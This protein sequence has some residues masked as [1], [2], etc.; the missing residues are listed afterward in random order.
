M[1][2]N[3]LQSNALGQT[4]NWICVT[5]RG[6]RRRAE[7]GGGR[8]RHSFLLHLCESVTANVAISLSF[9]SF[10]I[11]LFR[12]IALRTA[13]RYVATCRAP[14]DSKRRRESVKWNC[15]H[16]NWIS[17]FCILCI[18]FPSNVDR[19]R[20]ARQV[21]RADATRGWSDCGEASARVS[22]A[23]KTMCPK[24]PNRTS[25][26]QTRP[27]SVLEPVIS[28][29]R[30]F[31]YTVVFFYWKNDGRNDGMNFLSCYWRLS[32]N[33]GCLLNFYWGD[34]IVVTVSR[35][36][37]SLRVAW[38]ARLRRGAQS[39]QGNTYLNQT[40]RNRLELIR[41]RFLFLSSWLEL[42]AT[43]SQRSPT[44]FRWWI[45]RRRGR[46]QSIFSPS[47]IFYFLVHHKNEPATNGVVSNQSDFHC[48]MN[49]FHL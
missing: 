19:V 32:F 35:M 15:C 21:R 45:A 27:L 11:L 39:A 7:A 2:N 12:E 22:V 49:D 47:F 23:A 5:E 6:W 10:L 13:H 8:L 16:S 25:G 41:K 42:E 38:H 26:S 40:D 24:V 18:I 43:A 20:K 9:Y 14:Y 33:D 1:R 29:L 44:H 28:T 17:V 30:Y 34:D 37:G 4:S 48:L 36:R 46:H 3:W 31:Y